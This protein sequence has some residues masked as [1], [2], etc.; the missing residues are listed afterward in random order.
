[1]TDITANVVVSMPSQ[2]FTMARSF[3][4]VAN[5]KIYIGKIDT[6]PVNPENQ[7]QVYVENEDGSHVP[8]SQ[9]II[10]NAAGYPV[11]NGQ[12]AKFVTV[13]GHSMAVYDAYGAQQFYFPNVL[14]YDPDQLRVYINEMRDEILPGVVFP[15]DVRATAKVGD[16]IPVGTTDIHTEF[17]LFYIS[18]PASGTISS[19]SQNSAVIGGVTCYL[20]K[21]TRSRST[22]ISDWTSPDSDITSLISM[23]LIYFDE[24]Y[25]DIN[26][27]ITNNVISSLDN[28]KIL[29]INQ[30]RITL[31]GSLFNKSFGAI[32]LTGN[33]IEV[34]D[35]Y[36]N[37][38][39]DVTPLRMGNT[40]YG[41]ADS[42]RR[43]KIRA[44]RCT[45][46]GTGHKGVNHG[47]FVV[48]GAIDPEITMPR[49]IG[50]S[51]AGGNMEILGVK[52]GF[53][54]GGYAENGLLVN[55]H[56][57][58]ADGIGFPTTDF[59]FINCEGIHNSSVLG[60]V[61]GAIGGNNNIKLS[62]GCTN[63]KIVG[64]KF[65]SIANGAFNG[66]DSVIAIQGCSNNLIEDV[67]IFMNNNGDFKRAYDLYDHSESLTD[68]LDNKIRGGFVQINT[69]GQYNRIC[70]VRS[71]SGKSVRRNKLENVSFNC[72]NGSNTV[73]AIMEQFSSTSGMVS[74]QQ[75]TNCS[76]LG[77]STVL[78]NRAGLSA[79]AVTYLNGNR[80]GKVFDTY[81]L[82]TG[83]VKIINSPCVVNINSSGVLLSAVG[84][85]ASKKSPGVW[86]ITF[87]TDMSTAGYTFT[88]P[89]TG[90]Y[91]VVN[92]VSATSWTIVTYSNTGSPTEMECSI[93]FQ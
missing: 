13:H 58:S 79:T 39:S 88:S 64:G 62:R 56:A 4:A 91:M 33:N 37:G 10:I 40:S 32:E 43:S 14:K 44:I 69:P 31:T 41:S 34:R 52:G 24:I 76:G 72:F 60:N 70:N 6:D 83:V 42:T 9:P 11:Y 57:T 35:L 65:T 21:R 46:D 8:V 18:P 17:G 27:K 73:D 54:Q 28:K 45:F 92:K 61:D 90:R 67:L 16:I 20:E 78:R 71:D 89:G 3:K 68:C 93:S 51:K 55:Y 26:V 59:Q 29:A 49:F 50:Q 30:A 77:V 22:K 19:L 15:N 80:I 25:I 36:F 1:M 38:D 23:L 86:V 84:C 81:I 87:P 75:V 85:L 82:D 5:G 63:C 74:D 48:I 2:L 53:V 12:I 47:N 66:N 7:I